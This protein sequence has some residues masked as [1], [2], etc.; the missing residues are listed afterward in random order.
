MLKGLCGLSLHD[1]A[2]EKELS[3]VIDCSYAA[4]GLGLGLELWLGFGVEV[5]I[6]G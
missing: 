6:R 1:F 2:V 5:R 3:A 4:L